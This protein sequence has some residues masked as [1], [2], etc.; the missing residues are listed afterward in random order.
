MQSPSVVMPLVALLYI[1]VLSPAPYRLVV[2]ASHAEN[3]TNFGADKILVPDKIS[4]FQDFTYFRQTIA[5]V[6][7]TEL[8]VT[9][10]FAQFA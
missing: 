3:V 9:L 6:P 2:P 10:S 4:R 5:V 1:G 8:S 7:L